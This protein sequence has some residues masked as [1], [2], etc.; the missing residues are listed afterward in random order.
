MQKGLNKS[1]KGHEG[2][3]VSPRGTDFEKCQK[4]D[5]KTV[6]TLFNKPIL[7]YKMYRFFV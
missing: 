2:T 1:L 3:K 4:R 7:R 6:S 5:K